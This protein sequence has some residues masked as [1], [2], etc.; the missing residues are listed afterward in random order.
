MRYG[1]VSW[2]Y[3]LQYKV[4]SSLADMI[5]KLWVYNIYQLSKF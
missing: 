3:L 2:V 1:N 4:Q 5:M